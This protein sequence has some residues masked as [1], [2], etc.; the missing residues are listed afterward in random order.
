MHERSKRGTGKY[1]SESRNTGKRLGVVLNQLI[2]CAGPIQYDGVQVPQYVGLMV[3]LLNNVIFII[4]S[5]AR[6]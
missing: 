3:I 2:F 1:C 6:T 5:T 4:I